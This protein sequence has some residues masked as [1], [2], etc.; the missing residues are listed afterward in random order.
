[1]QISAIEIFTGEIFHFLANPGLHSEASGWEWIDDGAIAVCDGKILA[2]GKR[3]HLF[4]TYPD[5]K[6]NEHRGCLIMPGFIDTHV[7]Y[8]QLDVI[9]SFGSTLL[10]WLER[11][12]FPAEAAFENEAHAS[13][14]ANLF[15]DEMLRNGITTASVFPTVH[16]TSVE[17]FFEAA[18]ARNL[19]VLCGKVMMDRNCPAYLQ[20]TVSS[21]EK[22]NLSLIEKW[23]GKGRL[24][25]SLTPRFA[26]T[27][28]A[29]QLQMAGELLHAYP[30]IHL[31]SHLAENVDEIRWV[32]EL[33]P[34]SDS[35]LDVY[36]QFG[37]LGERSIFAHSVHLSSEDKMLM[38]KNQ[39]AIAFCPTSNLF[40]GSGFFDL[41]Q[42]VAHQ[43]PVGLATDIGGGTSFSMFRTMTAAYKVQQVHRHALTAWQAF[44]LSTL[45]GA[46]ALG[47]DAH[48]G[49]FEI[50]KEADFI[51][52]NPEAT[53]LLSRRYQ[54]TQTLEEKLFVLMML[55][56]DRVISGTYIA[57]K[58][59]SATLTG[60]C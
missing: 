16:K 5:A 32:K 17:A 13:L 7:H 37:L 11:Y 2:R 28:T 55:G 21:S 50:G 4:E 26:P 59:A 43:I 30:T 39:T 31:Q 24:L 54:L 48:V 25:Y 46:K 22:D 23:H 18:F 44:Y 20:D 36:D 60:D 45:G 10:D 35:Y 49:N 52:I 15:L 33:F 1:M 42:A 6:V 8:A 14:L 57:G 53:P 29:Q 19:R 56:D 41:S 51:I 12:T 47:I 58:N 34:T 38:G 3:T 27:S 9:A 40:L